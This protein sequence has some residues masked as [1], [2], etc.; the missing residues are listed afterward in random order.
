MTGISSRIRIFSNF[1]IVLFFLM[2][3]VQVSSA[4]DMV[5]NAQG[6]LHDFSSMAYEQQPYQSFNLSGLGHYGQW[7]GS[8]AALNGEFYLGGSAFS[9]TGSLNHAVNR[10]SI[11]NGFITSVSAGNNSIYYYGNYYVPWGGG[12]FENQYFPSNGTDL[13]VNVNFPLSFTGFDNGYT[14]TAAAHG[15]GV[16]V[17][18]ISN[19]FQQTAYLLVVNRT[20]VTKIVDNP[21]GYSGAGQAYVAYGNGEFLFVGVQ[22]GI[23]LG[24]FI[25]TNGNTLNISSVLQSIPVAYNTYNNG[26]AW[27]GTSF[28]I[29]SYL[30]LSFLDPGSLAVTQE[31]FSPGAQFVTSEGSSFI[32]GTG[33]YGSDLYVYRYANGNLSEI[34]SSVGI[35]TTGLTV[36]SQDGNVVVAGFPT[37]TSGSS[38]YPMLEYYTEEYRNITIVANAPET[39]LWIDGN[40]VIANGTISYSLP[41]GLNPIIAAKTGYS[42]FSGVANV[43]PRNHGVFFVRQVPMLPNVMV[44]TSS[45]SYYN[46]EVIQARDPAN[47]YL[48]EAWIA[49][50]GIEFSRSTDNG[51]TFSTP[52]A[53]PGSIDNSTQFSWDPAIAVSDNG[54]VYVSF[55]HE[56]D[57]ALYP[58]GGVPVVSISYNHGISFDGYHNVSTPNYS[59]F[60]D[61]DYIAV[62]P[63]GTIYVTWNYAPYYYMIGI[64][65]VPGSSGFYSSGDFNIVFSSSNNGGDTWST[66]VNLTPGYPYAGGV[67]APLLVQPDGQ[68]DV[69]FT[70]YNTSQYHVLGY[71]YEYFTY[72]TDGGVTW[73][74]PVLLGGYTYTLSN[75]NWWIDPTISYGGH[76]TIY[77]AFDYQHLSMDV[78]VI[79]YSHNN[80]HTWSSPV[81]LSNPVPYEPHIE[82]TVA[83][84]SDHIAYVTWMSHTNYSGWSIYLSKFNAWNNRVSPPIPVSQSFGMVN[85]WGGDT[86]G[87]SYL[88]HNSL[89]VSWGYG[90]FRGGDYF[91]SQIY[92]ENIHFDETGFVGFNY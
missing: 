64:E 80:G 50:D 31:P 32:V 54:T 56:Y 53:V 5:N 46:A 71:G 86:N 51:T 62:S 26:I 74:H 75:M 20:N 40:H 48:Y 77:I 72:S 89:E 49:T 30:G 60:G 90:V 70:N 38:N 18:I 43:T 10:I 57:A 44:S 29:I 84:A 61:R 36:A 24:G 92:A 59:G 2:T 13:Q 11:P 58:R 81:V 66:P 9:S 85:T 55:M 69:V 73:S 15:G 22:N 47:G 3:A 87:L 25:R 83:A 33:F 78:P 82:V 37:F 68:I 52:Y 76:G 63:Q 7:Y 16:S 79:V 14:M 67:E 21:F 88:G 17:M 39:S 27:N 65:S 91:S 35:Q 1:L 4:H 28:A 42:T 41:F 8:S 19:S 34:G 45:A 23:S 12:L 6:S